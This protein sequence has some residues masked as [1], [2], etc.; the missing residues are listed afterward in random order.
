VL[1]GLG[2]LLAHA[3]QHRH[4][5]HVHD[6]YVGAAHYELEL[7]QRLQEHHRLDV[8]HSAAHLLQCFAKE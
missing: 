8:A 2:L 4:Q 5:A 6:E 7:P 3:A 1:R